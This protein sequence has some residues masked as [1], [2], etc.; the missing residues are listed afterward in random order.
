MFICTSA[1]L[2]VE[3][4]RGT[5]LKALGAMAQKSSQGDQSGFRAQ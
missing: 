1:F 2:H 3:D 4:I 5:M